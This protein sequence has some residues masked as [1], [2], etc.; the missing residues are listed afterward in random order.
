[1]KALSVLLTAASLLLPV[2]ASLADDLKVKITSDLASVTVKHNGKDV[3][4]QRN[5][6]QNNTIAACVCQDIASLPAVLHS[7]CPDCA[8][9]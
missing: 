2:S 9:C 6:N 3:T 4:I 5:Q 7:A 1:M 8:G